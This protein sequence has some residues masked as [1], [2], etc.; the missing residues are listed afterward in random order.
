MRFS[1]N[2][3]YIEK[4]IFNFVIHGAVKVGTRHIVD[5]SKSSV[6]NSFVFFG[7]T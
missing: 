7:L 5:V 4:S 2:N 6:T 1:D 3:I